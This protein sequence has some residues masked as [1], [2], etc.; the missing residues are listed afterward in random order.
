MTGCLTAGPLATD[1]KQ[2]LKASYWEVPGGPKG[3]GGRRVC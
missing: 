1:W 3:M 2:V